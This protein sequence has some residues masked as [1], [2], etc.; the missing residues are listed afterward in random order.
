MVSI[1]EEPLV[2]AANATMLMNHRTSKAMTLLK[3][4]HDSEVRHTVQQIMDTFGKKSRTVVNGQVFEGLDAIEQF[5]K[6]LGFSDEGSFTNIEFDIFKYHQSDD[7][8]VIEFSLRG[9][10]TG[11]FKG[12]SPTGKLIDVPVAAIYS[13]DTNGTLVQE[14]IYFD[15][16][17]ILRQIG[18]LLS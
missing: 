1:F 10:H 9:T 3:A 16:A 7:A 2:G 15:E 13:Y 5:H 4:H 17:K 14:N 11:D 18:A 8:I 6:A 12:I